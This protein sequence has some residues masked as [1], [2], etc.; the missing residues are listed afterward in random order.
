MR[1]VMPSRATIANDPS[2]PRTAV[3]SADEHAR[4]GLVLGQVVEHVQGRVE[5]IDH[6]LDVTVHVARFY[7]CARASGR[8]AHANALG[9]RAH[10]HA[11]AGR[12]STACDIDRWRAG[13]D[14][15]RLRLQRVRLPR[16]SVP[17][18]GLAGPALI[19]AAW[20]AVSSLQLFPA[21]AVPAPGGGGSRPGDR[22]LQRA[23]GPGRAGV[24]LPRRRGLPAGHRRSASR[25]V[26]CSGTRRRRAPRCCRWSTSSG[27]C[28]RWRGSRS[29][30]SGS[31]SAI[32]RRSS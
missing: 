21:V 28:R 25:R 3:G 26:C 15:C 2:M 16:P 31:A 18:L 30:S 17:L 9:G 13:I 27:T 5:E 22:V 10:R 6:A 29:P 11:I 4:P 19:V 14:S 20:A 32:R 12:P 8:R 24:A 1:M 23:A 7:R